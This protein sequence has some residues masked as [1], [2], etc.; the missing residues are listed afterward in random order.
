VTLYRYATEEAE[1]RFIKGAFGQYMSPIVIDQLMDDPS[2]LNLGG[3]KKVLTAFFSDIQSFSSFSEKMEPDE[4]V[5]FLN[6]YLTEMCDIILKYDGTIDKF[7]G[8][9]IIAFF[10]APIDFP[11][12]AERASL[13]SAEIQ[14][15]MENFRIEWAK[16][17]WPAVHMRIGLNTG[18]IVVGN[19]GSRDRMD[20]T[21]MG[22]AVNLAARL[23]EAAKQYKIYSMISEFTY[24]AAKDVID[25]RELDST[26]V[27]GK[28][29]P[30][31]VYEILGKKGEV[32]EKKL[33]A[34]RTFEVGLKLYR[35]QKFEE[36]KKTFEDALK[37]NP[38][39]GP[40]IIFIDR[41]EDFIDSPPGEVWD[42]VYV[43]TKK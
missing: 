10:G 24:E 28:E 40:S 21:M 14:A 26:R 34:A 11:D 7:E 15:A 36:A 29:L 30:V 2:K 37:I 33:K 22:D 39:D 3:E 5:Q 16:D 4:L 9:A 18:D 23:E 8:D 1:K 6:I 41:C 17:G 43:M 32:E 12:H 42:G 25:V 20:Y 31:R 38:E 13:C 19:M 27:V 35:E